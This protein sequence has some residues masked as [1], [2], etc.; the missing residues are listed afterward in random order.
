MVKDAGEQPDEERSRVR[1]RRVPSTG[2][3]ASVELECVAILARGCI[4]WPG[5]SPSPILEGFL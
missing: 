1:S 4:C 3:A 2:A 5:S